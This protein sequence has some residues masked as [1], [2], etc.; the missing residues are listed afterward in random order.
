MHDLGTLQLVMLRTAG[1][2]QFEVQVLIDETSC[3]CEVMVDIVG[4]HHV[5]VDENPAIYIAWLEVETNI[6]PVSWPD[7]VLLKFCMPEI[8]WDGKGQGSRFE[9]S[10]VSLE[11]LIFTCIVLNHQY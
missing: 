10:H 7:V 6:V 4:I 5:V 11:V 2:W 8:G 9:Q 1:V 3:M